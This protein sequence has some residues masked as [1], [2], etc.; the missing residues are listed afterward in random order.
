MH[1]EAIYAIHVEHIRETDVDAFVTAICGVAEKYEEVMGATF[2]RTII[3]VTQAV[4][5]SVDAEGRPFTWDLL[6]DAF[7]R[8]EIMFDEDGKHRLQIMIDPKTW[9]LPQ[10]IERTPEQEQRFRKIMR[11]KKEAWDAQ[12]RTRRLPRREQG[13]RA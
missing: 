11:R 7:E 10:A 2:A 13:A 9:R 3:D 8:M 5:N 1:F 6:L 4:G 12:Q